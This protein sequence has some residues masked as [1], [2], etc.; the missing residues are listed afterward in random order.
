M[1]ISVFFG[2]RLRARHVERAARAIDAVGARP[3]RVAGAVDVAQQEVG[4]VDQHVAVAFGRDREAPQHRLGERVLDRLRSARFVLVE[5]NDWFGCTISTR[6]PTRWNDTSRPAPLPRSSPMSFE[7][8][9]AAR[10]VVNRNSVSNRGISRNRGRC[11]RPSRAGRSRRSSAC[12]RCAPRSSESAAGLRINRKHGYN[13]SDCCGSSSD[14]R[15][16]LGFYSTFLGTGSWPVDLLPYL[17]RICAP[18]GAANRGC[19]RLSGGFSVHAVPPA[20]PPPP[21]T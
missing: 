7:P 15:N 3:Q 1:S 10:P 2:K 21:R 17:P 6:G 9:P 13:N 8:S 5:R 19:S 14:H 12:R 18:C 16:P 11:A 4:R 20:H